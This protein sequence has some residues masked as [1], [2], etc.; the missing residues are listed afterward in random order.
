[1]LHKVRKEGIKFCHDCPKSKGTRN[2]ILAQVN[3]KDSGKRS[4]MKLNPYFWLVSHYGM[5]AKI[6][7]KL[8]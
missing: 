5:F 7:I 3:I 8:L 1:M 4:F 2:K 6:G